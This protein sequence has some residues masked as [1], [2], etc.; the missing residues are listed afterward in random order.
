MLY[1]TVYLIISYI[2][3]NAK[4]QQTAQD[5]KLLAGVMILMALIVGLGDMLGG[6]DRYIYGQGF[7]NLA[8]DIKAGLDPVRPDAVIMSYSSERAWVWWNVLVGHISGNRYIFIMLTTFLAYILLY[9]SLKDYIENYAFGVLMF[10]ALFMFFTFTYL[11][12]VLATCFAWFSFRYIIDKKLWKFLICWFIAYEFHNSAIIFLPMYFIPM[13]KYSK[14]TVI[15]VM[16]VLLIIGMTGVSASLYDIYG[17]ASGTDARTA[18][19]E[20]TGHTFRPEYCLEV[21]VFLYLIFKRYDQIPDDRKHL[22]FLNAC[23][24]FCAIMLFF[25][26]N[27]SAG[28]QCWYYMIGIIFTLTY[29]ATHG[30]FD[31]NYTLILYSI[32]TALFLRFAIG[33]GSMV[34]PY[35]TFL[36][37]GHRANDGIYRTLEYDGNYD[38]DKLYRPAFYWKW[39]KND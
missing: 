29:L 24:M 10:S 30:R 17:D 38:K 15:Y 39:G 7:D 3:F 32:M 21:F 27:S 35:K 33:W 18:Y 26:T 8:D 19:Y 23:Y 4:N 22:V 25:V 12:Q 36:T 1:I 9:Q 37:N 20:E 16:A 31:K 11:R 14:K 6:Y 28:R 2:F 5:T 34:N 13:K